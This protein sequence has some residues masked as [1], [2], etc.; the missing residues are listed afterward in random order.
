MAAT[1]VEGY[2]C[3]YEASDG[4]TGNP[5]KTVWQ[6]FVGAQPVTTENHYLAETMRL[7]VETNSKVKVTYDPA[8]GNTMSQARIEFKYVCEKRMVEP[9][10]NN[11]GA[12]PKEVCQTL[13]YSP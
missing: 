6:F 11:P 3:V 1:Q 5:A 7:A 8:A 10:G 2:V 9:C 4:G 13:R 12:P